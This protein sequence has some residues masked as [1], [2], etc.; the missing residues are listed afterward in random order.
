VT[1]LT[2]A[3]QEKAQWFELE[4]AIQNISDRINRGQAVARFLAAEARL[5]E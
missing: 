2:Q 3:A 5:A 1:W 4:H